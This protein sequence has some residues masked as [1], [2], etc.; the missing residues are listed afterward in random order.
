MYCMLSY[1]LIYIEFSLYIGTSYV[2]CIQCTCIYYNIHI[3]C[4]L[5]VMYI[6]LKLFHNV[7][8]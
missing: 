1:E 4:L 3:V 8:Y 5:F 7:V 6:V 2:I